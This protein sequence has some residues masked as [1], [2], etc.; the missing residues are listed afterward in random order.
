M[1]PNCFGT[2][3]QNQ[4]KLP[5]PPLVS[6][7]GSNLARAIASSKAPCDFSDAASRDCPLTSRPDS[8]TAP[9]HASRSHRNRVCTTGEILA[10]IED[11][12]AVRAWMQL[13]LCNA[14]LHYVFTT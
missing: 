12:G 13:R 14:T 4:G 1:F 5:V 2:A 9:P 11:A 3:R 8:I 10:G 7:C 6:S